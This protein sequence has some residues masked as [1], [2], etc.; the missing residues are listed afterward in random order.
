[1]Y[2]IIIPTL[3][4]EILLPAL[5]KQLSDTELKKK[6][7][8][9]IIISD[10]GSKDKTIDIAKKYADKI[11]YNA[12]GKIQNIA[13]GRNI[14]ASQ[15]EG[16][17]LIFLNGDVMIKDPVKFFY[18]VE[19]VFARSRYAAMT[20]PVKVP[21]EQE[22]LSDKL[23]H[24]FYN[25]YFNFLN[26]VG[27]GMGRGECQVIKRYM[28]EVIG[29]NNE[30]LAA[31]EDFDL[32]RKIRRRGKVLFAKGLVIYESPRRYRKLGYFNVTFSW[33]KNSVSV[34]IKNKSISK[35]WEQIR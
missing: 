15:A 5:L 14:G 25:T 10:G 20:C 16:E 22:L 8:Y 13:I 18:F 1:M 35:E 28:F 31:G 21:P 30:N 9:E 3:N 11:C 26:I 33:L 17:I 4:E 12:D 34:V 19:N 7:C 24:G 2:T 29:G 6:Y 27:M 32:F 23:F